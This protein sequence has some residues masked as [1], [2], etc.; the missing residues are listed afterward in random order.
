M[1]VLFGTAFTDRSV[2]VV[3]ESVRI[4]PFILM[5]GRN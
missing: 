2:R 3:C 4:M 5:V 1:V